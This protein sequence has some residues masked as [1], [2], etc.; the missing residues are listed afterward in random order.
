[1]MYN[2]FMNETQASNRQDFFVV[3][4][5]VL[6]FLNLIPVIINYYSCLSLNS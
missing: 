1:M 2:N 6:R 3:G 5:F 4:L